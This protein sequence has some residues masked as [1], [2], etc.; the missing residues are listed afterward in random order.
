MD[1]APSNRAPL[2]APFTKENVNYARLCRLL[3]DCGTKAL[4]ITFEGFFT[5]ASPQGF[6]ARPSVYTS[7]KKLYKERSGVLHN[8]HWSR[9]YPTPPSS[10]SLE[11]FDITLL[12]VLLR[13]TC[14][15]TPPATGWDSLPS[16]SDKSLEANIARVKHYRNWV[17]GHATEASV[18]DPTF[19]ALWQ[20]ISSALMKLG[21]DAHTIY[22]L[23]CE[24][25][26][27]ETKQ[28]YE[29]LLE[30][31]RKE[32]DTI[33]NK[34]TAMESMNKCYQASFKG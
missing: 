15:L 19:N 1:L 21:I 23:R 17:Y 20:D 8:L 30:E 25:M 5:P 4:R 22:V 3:I 24:S 31:Y 28:Y 33:R 34:V 32:E 12:M 27:P 13:N 10:P 14:G 6:L 7:L 29:E 9:L 18:D 2:V 16:P 11:D 26:D